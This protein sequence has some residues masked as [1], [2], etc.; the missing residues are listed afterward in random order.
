M[1]H[2]ADAAAIEVNDAPNWRVQDVLQY[3]QAQGKR[4]A[5]QIR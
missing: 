3:K 5:K 1:N 4:Q 2:D